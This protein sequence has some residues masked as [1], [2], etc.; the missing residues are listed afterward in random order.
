LKYLILRTPSG[1][2]PVLF[3]RAFMHAHVAQM[4]KPM[5]VVAAGFVTGAD[6]A[7]QCHGA[8]AGLH[9][10]SRPGIDTAI[11]NNALKDGPVTPAV[12]APGDPRA[13]VH[14]K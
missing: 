4:F 14:D 6:D 10:A 3:P 8:S 2:A 1:E 9:I 5:D 11:L 7:L 13:N 12:P